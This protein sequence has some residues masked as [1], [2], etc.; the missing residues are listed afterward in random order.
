MCMTIAKSH[1]AILITRYVRLSCSSST[2]MHSLTEIFMAVS[3]SSTSS[4]IANERQCLTLKHASFVSFH[5]RI[6]LASYL[7]LDSKMQNGF[8]W[9]SH[10]IYFLWEFSRIVVRLAY[11]SRGENFKLLKWCYRFRKTVR[12]KCQTPPV[13]ILR[14][15]HALVIDHPPSTEQ[16]VSHIVHRSGYELIGAFIWPTPA[17]TTVRRSDNEPTKND[18]RKHF[19]PFRIT[20]FD[21]TVVAV[22]HC[23]L[24]LFTFV[25][26]G[27][28][29][30]Y[31]GPH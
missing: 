3:S 17:V 31:H 1:N 14:I 2:W 15:T 4:W 12:P 23:W 21:F 18:T 8:H 30:A 22:A 9:N 27:L 26:S 29:D 5:F 19:R 7:S 6:S 10:W 24:L 13:T 11:R 25:L 16:F 20:E 28:H